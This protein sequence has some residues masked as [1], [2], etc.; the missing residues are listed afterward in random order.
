MGAI[1]GVKGLVTLVPA[2]HG[3]QTIL[4]TRWNGTF[5]RELHEISSFDD[6]TNEREFV[7]G[8][9]HMTGTIEGTVDDAATP[10]LAQLQ[11]EDSVG[12][13]GFQLDLVSGARFYSMTAIFS[14]LTVES[15]KNALATFSMAF[16]SSGDVSKDS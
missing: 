9:Y 3:G 13:S 11:A 10:L 15:T 4:I 7:G 2:T 16:E 14:N 5:D 6:Q 12:N 1:T 8:A